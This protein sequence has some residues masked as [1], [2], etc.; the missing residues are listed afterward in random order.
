M[1][2]HG[3]FNRFKARADFNNA[4]VSGE[5]ASADTKAAEMYPEILMF[6]IPC[7]LIIY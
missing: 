6:F 1:A 5:A 7:S 4:K 3:W 2:G